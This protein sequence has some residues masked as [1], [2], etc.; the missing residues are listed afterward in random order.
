MLLSL[1][2]ASGLGAYLSVGHLVEARAREKSYL[3]R[4]GRH[5]SQNGAKTLRIV[6]VD[7]V[8]ARP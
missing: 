7:R 8:D 5:G 4:W 6:G 1:E 3:P 2:L